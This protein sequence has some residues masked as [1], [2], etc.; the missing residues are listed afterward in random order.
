MSQALVETRKLCKEFKI[1]GENSL[2]AKTFSAVKDVNIAVYS[3]ETFG[4]VGESGRGKS[5]V[6]KLI[7]CIEKPTAGEVYLKGQR[8][9]SLPEGERRRLRPRFQMVFQDSGSSL[10]PRKRVGDIIREPLLYHRPGK[11]TEADSRVVLQSAVSVNLYRC[12]SEV[13]K[14]EIQVTV[15]ESDK[16]VMVKVTLQAEGSTMEWV[17]VTYP[18]GVDISRVQ[19]VTL[20]LPDDRNYVCMIYLDGVLDKRIEMEGV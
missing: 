17:Y 19:K 4:I 12:P 11:G 2:F 18:C 7:M 6:A 10:N 16:E 8:I 20:E 15:P 1:S 13:R 9:D 5:T 14:Q 3:G